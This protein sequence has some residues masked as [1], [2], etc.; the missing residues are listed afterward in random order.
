MLIIYDT[1]NAFKGYIGL[2]NKKRP[3]STIKV[4]IFFTLTKLGV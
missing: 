4:D 2:N 3:H 1:N